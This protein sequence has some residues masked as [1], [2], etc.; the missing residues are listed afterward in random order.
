MGVCE[1]PG[2]DINNTSSHSFYCDDVHIELPDLPDNFYQVDA[3]HVDDASDFDWGVQ[4]VVAGDE[5]A[6]HW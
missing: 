2:T 5:K 3:H 6:D 4:V 1:C